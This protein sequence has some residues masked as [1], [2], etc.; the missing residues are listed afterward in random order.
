MGEINLEDEFY[1]EYDLIKSR[2]NPSKL[3]LATHQYEAVR[4]LKEWFINRSNEDKGGILVLPTGGG[5]TFT[6]VRFLCQYPLSDGYKVLWLAHTHHLLEQAFFS[7]GPKYGQ[8]EQG[9]EVGFIQEPKNKLNI[10]VV[11]GTREHFKVNEIEPEDDVIISTLQSI[12]RAYKNNHPILKEFLKSAGEKLF[13]VFDEAHHSPAPSYRNLLLKLREQ[14]EDIYLLGLTATPTYSDEKKIG[15]LHDLFPQKILYQISINDL[16]ARNILAEPNFEKPKKTHFEPD[17][18]D[19]EYQKWV[20]TFRDLPEYVID[21]LAKNKNRNMFI[22]KTYAENRDK[23]GK[24]LIFADRKEQCVQLTEFLRAENVKAGYMFSGIYKTKGGRVFGGDHENARTLQR[25]KDGDLQVL[26][27]IRMLTEGTDVPDVNSVFLTRQ[28]TSQI[29][30]TQMIGRALRGPD[31]NGTD[32]A[33]IVSFVDDWKQKINW[34]DWHLGP[35]VPVAPEPDTP[36]EQYKP[37]DLISLDSVAHLS[38][39][40]YDKNGIETGPFLKSIPVGWYQSSFYALAEGSDDYELVNRLLLVF[41]NEKE[42]Y[43]NLMDKFEKTDISD[44]KDEEINFDDYSELIE[45]WSEEFFLENDLATGDIM[46]NI[47]YLACHMAQNFKERPPFFQFKEREEHD[48]DSIAKKVINL[49]VIDADTR[50]REEFERDD[51]FW[52]TIYPNYQLFKQQFDACVNRILNIQEEKHKIESTYTSKKP[53]KGPDKELRDKI[54]NRDN[55]LCLCCGEDREYLLDVDHVNPRYFG[56]SNSSENLQT[57]CNRC[58]RV[59]GTKEID[60]RITNALINLPPHELPLIK[61]PSTEKADDMEEW[62]KFLKRMINFFYGCSA[63]KKTDL[64]NSIWKIE[65]NEGN[66]IQWIQPH[67]NTI[68]KEVTEIRNKAG[69]TGPENIIISAVPNNMEKLIKDLEMGNST[70]R[71]KAIIKLTEMDN[72][73]EETKLLIRKAAQDDD[74]FVRHYAN[75]ALL[76]E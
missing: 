27:N 36:P 60:F 74:S 47:F 70:Q 21:Q 9:Y 57:L 39:I 42:A 19:R 61:L 76:N 66:E 17:F 30:L 75:K 23:Y 6:A 63:V 49:S 10:R 11:S 14:F 62:S 28:T 69:L 3:N 51:R 53:N 4:K 18:D 67:L 20:N 52:K 33:N 68:L 41:E 56:G 31:F 54:R 15:W 44:F 73:D 22:A 32:I 71:R 38:S 46:N 72:L 25:F 35:E 37:L 50:L 45:N 58:N 5:K 40:M 43:E 55:H 16:M 24:T 59:K 1:R 29:L 13:V 65:I 8:E 7:F 12:S 2:R 34:A 48:M 64:I 26:V